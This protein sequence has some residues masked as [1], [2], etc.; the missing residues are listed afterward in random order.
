[1]ESS[2]VDAQ[3]CLQVVTWFLKRCL[4]C[5][6]EY[7]VA[8]KT[9]QT[10]E[11]VL[12]SISRLLKA[13][14]FETRCYKRGQAAVSVDFGGTHYVDNL[15]ATMG[16]KH[17]APSLLDYCRDFGKAMRESIK[18][19]TNWSVKYFTHRRS[20]YPV[21]EVAMD[22]SAI[23]ELISIPVVPMTETNLANMGEW[24]SEHG[25]CVRR[26]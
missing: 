16:M 12:K 22:L 10:C 3:T 18:R 4:R 7:S 1:M 11:L 17:P 19:I 20:Y 2:L 26:I 13:S 23:A 24:A 15:H 8:N 9:M 6:R 14:E 5:T 21:P 25:Q